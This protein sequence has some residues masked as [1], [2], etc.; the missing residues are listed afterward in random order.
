MI[1]SHLMNIE[2]RFS[3]ISVLCVI[4]YLSEIKYVF[5]MMHIQWCCYNIKRD[6]SAEIHSIYRFPSALTGYLTISV[7][8]I[9]GHGK[10]C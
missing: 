7:F 3:S 6:K 9:Q 8:E 5:I 4:I 10:Q 1:K 2:V